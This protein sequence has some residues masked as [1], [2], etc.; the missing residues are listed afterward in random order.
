MEAGAIRPI[1]IFYCYAHEDDALQEQ[2]AKHLSLLRRLKDIVTWSHR[3]IQAGAEWKR[4]SETQLD[5]ANV[6]LVLIS[7]DFMASDYCY[8]VELAHALKRHK[9][10][11]AWVIPILLRPV[12]WERS[13]LG[14]LSPLPTNKTPV[15]QWA[16]PDA[17]WL[18]VVQGIGEIV[19]KLLP[20]QLLSAK[21]A[22]LL[23]AEQGVLS[24]QTIGEKYLLGELI[25]EGEFSQ[26]YQAQHLRIQRQ[27]AVKVLLERPFRNQKFYER[28]L[29]EAQIVAS[30]NHPNIIPLHDFG[31]EAPRA[32]LVMPYISGGTFQSLLEK[33]R[34]FLTLEQVVFY[35]KQICDALDYAHKQG[36]VHLDI[37][38]LN[39]LVHADGRLLLSDFGLAHLMKDGKIAGG[40]SLRGGTP[41]YM[42]PEHI[43]G[44]PEKRSDLF[45]LGVMLYQ[46]LVGRLPFDG[47]PETILLKNRTELP[48][49]P[50]F[51]R[52]ELPR[53]VEDMLE[54]AL[55]KKPEHRYQTA[56]DL[57]AA[58]KQA[59]AVSVQ[60]ETHL[61]DGPFSSPFPFLSSS[62]VIR[63]PPQWQAWP[64]RHTNDPSTSRCGKCNGALLLGPSGPVRH[65]WSCGHINRSDA[66]F[67]NTC[68]KAQVSLFQQIL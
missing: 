27:Q 62:V 64:C 59:L 16:N 52:P 32:Y 14:V 6:I 9:A 30:L 41:H 17:A 29:R 37:K 57:L 28:F 31:W 4:E 67:C 2:L 24:G 68:G 44:F 20:Q 5:D 39:L 53:G 12:D 3:H 15:T 7:A 43:E 47:L 35:L 21:D 33:Q 49:A 51:R 54:K 18:S 50:R 36:V 23:Y 48:L 19:R 66:N 22:D 10:G 55:A 26:V 1:K 65:V 25:G 42:A 46:M 13:P 61:Q 38:P 56:S 40:S 11:D 60:P 45:S 34:K 58:F 63:H 8:T